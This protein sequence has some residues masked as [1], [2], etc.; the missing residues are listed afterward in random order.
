MAAIFCKHRF[1]QKMPVFPLHRA[2]R[3]L[4]SGTIFDLVHHPKG[5][6]LGRK[7]L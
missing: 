1:S 4:I 6:C 3:C 2:I 5:C 7:Q